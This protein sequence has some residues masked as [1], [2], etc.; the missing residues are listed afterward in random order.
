VCGSHPVSGDAHC[1]ISAGLG[2]SICN[3]IMGCWIGML[4]KVLMIHCS[5]CANHGQA[6]SCH[7]EPKGWGP[8]RLYH[9]ITLCIFVLCTSFDSDSHTVY[10]CRCHYILPIS[11]YIKADSDSHCSSCR[12]HYHTQH[13]A[14]HVQQPAGRC[15]LLAPQ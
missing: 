14:N 7:S 6:S 2:A 4:T 8:L 13:T 10:D 11:L 3:T 9:I 5:M 12:S 15:H 1:I